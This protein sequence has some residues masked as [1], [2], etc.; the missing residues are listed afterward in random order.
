MAD[1]LLVLGAHLLPKTLPKL[2]E[3]PND[4]LFLDFKTPYSFLELL[5][6]LDGLS[7][8]ELALESLLLQGLLV[9]AILL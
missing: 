3:F 1:G 7:E 6:V 2:I 5:V 8:L 4:V 9:G